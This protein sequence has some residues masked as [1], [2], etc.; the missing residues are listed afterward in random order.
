MT[1]SLLKK[2]REIGDRKKTQGKNV[3]E[4][5]MKGA[6]QKDRSEKAKERNREWRS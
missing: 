5:I 3:S 6:R 4:R 1:G 2:K